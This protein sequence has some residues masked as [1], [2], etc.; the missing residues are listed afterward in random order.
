M[1]CSMET[2]IPT[3]VVMLLDNCRMIASSKS[4]MFRI[5]SPG[6]VQGVQLDLKSS[7]LTGFFI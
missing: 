5:Q 6:W 1:I 2:V 3:K 4:L 7:K